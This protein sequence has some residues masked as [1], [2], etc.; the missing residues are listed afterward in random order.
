M[1]DSNH[2]DGSNYGYVPTASWC[3]AYIVLFSVTAA[4]HSAQAWR[5]KYWVVFPTLVLGALVE[6]MGW[7][8]RYWSNKNV[9]LLT[10]FLMQ[11]STLIIA[12]V[13]F[14]AWDYI[15]LG[16]A[17][18]RLG[19]QYSLLRP[20]WYLATFLTADI[21][22]LVVQAVGG[23]EASAA[24]ADGSP[25]ES[26]TNTMV[27][28]IIFQ[29][30]CMLIFVTLGTDFMLRATAR[31]PYAFQEKRLARLASGEAIPSKRTWYG[32]KKVVGGTG[33]EEKVNSEGVQRDG[34]A[35]TLGTATAIGSPKP[36]GH[37]PELGLGAA[38]RREAEENERANLNRWWI[39]LAGA[40]FSS[41][42][43]LMRGVYR[44]VELLQGW[45][46]FLIT[47]EMY[48]NLLDG[49]PMLLAVVVFN[50]LHPGYLLPK[51]TTWKG[52]H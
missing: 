32:K 29:A 38:E 50:F 36:E 2:S 44:S 18:S 37:H 15:V 34:D 24:A 17:I 3:L 22:S 52:Y 11:I 20:N 7:A 14:S 51:R 6:V 35:D 30:V 33:A 31:R 41:C 39:M 21:I 1:S 4:V 8:A 42:M 46:G 12:P 16:M 23:G 13:F 45:S 19:P 26:A 43:I 9:T 5:S 27:G 47:H 25:T 10:P 40:L 48:Q 28:G 49:L